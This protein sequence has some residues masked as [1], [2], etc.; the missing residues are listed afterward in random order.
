MSLLYF[1][2]TP[3]RTLAPALPSQFPGLIGSEVELRH[4]TIYNRTCVKDRVEQEHSTCDKTTQPPREADDG[5]WNTILRLRRRSTRQ[6][7]PTLPH[8]VPP[9]Q[10]IAK[11]T[12]RIAPPPPTVP[13]C[14]HLEPG[15][16]L[17][18]PPHRLIAVI[19]TLPQN[20]NLQRRQLHVYCHCVR[21]TFA[22][23][24]QP[25]RTKISGL[26]RQSDVTA[27]LQ[28][29]IKFELL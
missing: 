4:A 17:F 22:T 14:D 2:S 18:N 15:N 10:F 27:N 25:L 23:A 20:N 24:D 5:D 21:D 13:P 7:H 16:V 6:I 29:H 8:R 3:T 26:F 9:T 11:C 1:I 28:T 19:K 12:P